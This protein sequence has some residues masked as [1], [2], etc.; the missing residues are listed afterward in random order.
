MA[1]TSNSLSSYSTLQRRSQTAPIFTPDGDG[2]TPYNYIIV[3]DAG[4][5]GS[6]AYLYAY[7]STLKEGDDGTTLP[8]LIHSSSWRMTVKPSIEASLLEYGIHDLYINEY[9]DHLLAKLYHIVPI[10]QHYRTPVFFHATAGLRAL[11]P[12]LQS[13]I[14]TKICTYLQE[15]VDFYVPDCATHVNILDGDIEGMYSWITLNY[16][17]NKK[18]DS[19]IPM[20]DIVNVEENDPSYGLLQLGGGSAQ[21]CFQPREET[22]NTQNAMQLLKLNLSESN[23]YNLY[24]TSFL[25]FGLNQVHHEY[26]L[27]LIYKYEQNVL[28]NGAT[29]DKI[30][31]DACS[32]IDHELT[33]TYNNKQYQ[34]KG[35]S[36]F[37][38]CRDNIYS[39]II[40]NVNTCSP[41]LDESVEDSTTNA[42]TTAHPFKVSKCVL[43]PRIPEFNLEADHFV[44][45]SGYWDTITDMMKFTGQFHK[46]KSKSKSILYDPA[47]FIQATRDVCSSRLNTLT[48]EGKGKGKGKGKHMSPEEIS[49][50]CFKSTYVSSLLHS[51]FGLPLETPEIDTESSSIELSPHLL[52]ND[53]IENVKF[54]WTLGRALLYAVD[55]YARQRN[56][57]AKVGYWRSSSSNL[58]YHGSEQQGVLTRPEY[59]E[60]SQY[61]TCTFHFESANPTPVKNADAATQTTVID[62]YDDFDSGRDDLDETA[63][64]EYQIPANNVDSG[65]N[66]DNDNDADIDSDDSEFVYKPHHSIGKLV[67]KIISS[68]LLVFVLLVAIPLTRRWLVIALTK[69]RRLVKGYTSIQRDQSNTSPLSSRDSSTPAEFASLS[70]K[71]LRKFHLNNGGIELNDL[72]RVSQPSNVDNVLFNDVMSASEIDDDDLEGDALDE[73]DEWDN[74]SDGIERAI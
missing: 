53:D 60:K 29:D 39:L 45:I 51:S 59:E 43:N 33:M 25:G 57:D 11:D 74:D 66:F 62:Y 71:N 21:I 23:T 24:S 49:S 72:N 1:P 10:Q 36:D 65:A 52:L 5:K 37:M 18:D 63:D 2:S 47:A 27:N 15:N 8:N 20:H 68:I 3:I 26:L 61:T 41:L 42:D 50:L 4:S 44:A 48:S 16:L 70:D 55:E 19:N 35:T 56:P 6:R 58:F 28:N 46:S 9:L 64:S 38:Q 17:M 14:L 54:T 12:T 30:L 69:A 31:R 73:F 13:K 7:D 32:P 34:I 22:I 40:A 67:V